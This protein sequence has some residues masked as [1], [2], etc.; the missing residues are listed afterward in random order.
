MAKINFDDL[1]IFEDQDYIVINKP[2]QISTLDDRSGT[3]ASILGMAR[4]YHPDAQMNHRLDKET[5]G[6]LAIAKNPEAYRALSIQFEDRKVK[7]IYHALC[8]GLHNFK[9]HV[10]KSAILTL[11]K[12]TVKIDNKEGKPA[13][14]IFN[15]LHAYKRHTLVAC[16]PIT[17]RMHQ[18]RIHLS[19]IKA[20]ITGDEQYGGK[21]FFLS[22]VKKKF[23]LKKDT[24]ELPLFRRVALHAN[25]LSFTLMNGE[26]VEITAPYPKDFQILI[27]QLEKNS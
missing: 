21:P 14:T 25:A 11:T 2:S 5:T 24:E 23:N 12:G 22:S 26:V 9:D 16:M 3:G 18:I 8:D 27:N 10:V 17:G 1:I 7:K 13:E 20:P 15:T 19:S 4:K 6:A